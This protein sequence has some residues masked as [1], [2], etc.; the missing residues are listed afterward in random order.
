MTKILGEGLEATV[1]NLEE[2]RDLWKEYESAEPEAD[3][4]RMAGSTVP[5]E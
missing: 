2:L 3:G 1:T 4:G 5:D